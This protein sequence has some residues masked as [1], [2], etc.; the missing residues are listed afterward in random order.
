MPSGLLPDQRGLEN[1]A[2][3]IGASPS[4]SVAGGGF[5]SSVSFQEAVSFSLFLNGNL[6]RAL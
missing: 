5:E 4:C 6:S 1:F 3:L 2:V